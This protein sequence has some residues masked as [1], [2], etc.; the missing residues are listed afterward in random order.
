VKVAIV[1]TGVSGLVAAHRLHPS[2][3]ITVFEADARTGGHANTVTVTVDGVDHAVDTG[4]IVYNERNYPGFVA[5]LRDLGVATQ[6]AEMSFGVSDPRSGL[7][8]RASNLHTLFAQRRNLVNPRFLRLLTEIVRFNRAARRLV[9]DDEIWSGADRLDPPADTDESIADFLARGRYSAMFVEQFLVPFGAAIWSADPTSFTRFPVRSYAR[10]MHN[11]G[12]LGVAARTEWRTI[13][14]GSRR[15]VD[16]LTA[17]FA[18]RIRCATPVHKIV[19]TARRDGAPAVE[20]LTDAGPCTF[21]RVVVATHADQALRMLGDA[22]PTE[23]AVLGALASQRNTA[24]LHTDDRMLPRRPAARA[25]WNYRVDPTARRA[26]VTYWMNNLQRIDSTRPLLLTLNGADAV[27]PERV[28]AGFE[29]EHPVFDAAAMHAQRRR[30]ELQGARG[31][32]FAGAYWGYG[33][34]EDGVQSGLEAAAAVAG[35]R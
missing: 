11:H 24:T 35:R 19:T 33:F 14:G 25:S 32:A 5:L 34:H 22:T 17:P 31:I 26:T 6:P 16:A 9:G 27:D 20:L 15:Y 8:Y 2:H 10:F 23:R 30:R 13:T 12:L 18:D 4:F 21:D 3:E 7:E 1:G 29:Y 28:L